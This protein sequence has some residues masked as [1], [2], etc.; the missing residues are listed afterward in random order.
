M[1]VGDRYTEER[2]NGKKHR[3]PNRQ[4]VQIWQIYRSWIPCTMLGRHGAL[5]YGFDFD[6]LGQRG[7]K[8]QKQPVKFIP[9]S[10]LFSPVP[11]FPEGF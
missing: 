6:A 8:G 9:V 1:E 5:I 11:E 10:L 7:Q 2:E 3:L 4:T